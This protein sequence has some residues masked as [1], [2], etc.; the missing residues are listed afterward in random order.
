MTIS[1][2]FKI[3][4]LEALVK[5]CDH[6]DNESDDDINRAICNQ[7]AGKFELILMMRNQGE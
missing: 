2:S 3:E 1:V 5:A 6:F 4:E 7:L